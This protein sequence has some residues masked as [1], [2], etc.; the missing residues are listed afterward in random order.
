MVPSRRT[1]L[2]SRKWKRDDSAR[3]IAGTSYAARHSLRLRWPPYRVSTGSIAPFNVYKEH[4]RPALVAPHQAGVADNVCGQDRRQFALLTGQEN[5]PALLQRIVEGSN[6][7]INSAEGAPELPTPSQRIMPS[8][9]LAG[10]RRPDQ[11]LP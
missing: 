10:Q 3:V 6:L 1:R 8:S 4:Q 5:F 11:A 2:L 7:L 9:N